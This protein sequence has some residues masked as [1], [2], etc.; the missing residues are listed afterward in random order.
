[1]TLDTSADLAMLLPL[2][3]TQGAR[4][5]DVFFVDLSNYPDFFDD[6]RQ[7]MWIHYNTGSVGRSK[8]LAAM[9]TLLVQNVGTF[10]ASFAPTRADL[11][12]LDAR[13]Q[14]DR[15]VWRKLP[16][17]EDFGFAVFKLRAGC[18]RVHPM[19][20]KFPRRQPK[21]LFFPTVHVHD[22]HSVPARATFDH[23]LYFQTAL[24]VDLKGRWLTS[25][26][27]AANFMRQ[28]SLP[29]DLMDLNQPCHLIPIHGKHVNRDVYLRERRG[30]RMGRTR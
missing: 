29:P 5:L 8:S 15:E 12:R 3:V 11:D 4:E 19:A 25:A 6:V 7:A 2:P 9:P 27:P 26:T 28:T 21:S 16:I 14:L 18:K 20:L 30:G 17:Y 10:E 22:A 24:K 23:S 13:F 1:M